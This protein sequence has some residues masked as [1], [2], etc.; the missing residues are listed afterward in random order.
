MLL[1]LRVENLLLIERARAAAR[2]R[3]Q[4]PDGETGGRQDGA[5][6]RARPAP[7]RPGADR[8]RSARGRPRRT[9][10]APF[11]LPEALRAEL[12]DRLPEDAEESCWRA[13]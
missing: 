5:R 8:D 11:E 4:R 6:A 10:R 9:W 3:A 13:A 7:R 2:A 12:A 1:E